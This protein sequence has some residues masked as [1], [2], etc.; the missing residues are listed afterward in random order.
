MFNLLKTIT[1]N[2]VFYVPLSFQ[3][4]PMQRSY[5]NNLEWKPVLGAIRILNLF[6][7]GA[8]SN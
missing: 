7:V 3:N 5:S 2:L 6:R 4:L 8:N 1:Y